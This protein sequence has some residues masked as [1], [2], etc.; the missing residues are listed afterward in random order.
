MNVPFHFIIVTE[1]GSKMDRQLNWFKEK[2][3]ISL[4]L[5]YVCRKKSLLRVQAN[6]KD[7]EIYY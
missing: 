1:N 4:A 3:K 6:L 2:R 5:F 7:K